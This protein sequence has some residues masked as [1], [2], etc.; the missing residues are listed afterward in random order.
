[1]IV[2]PMAE[3]TVHFYLDEITGNECYH[4]MKM[5]RSGRTLRDEE[6]IIMKM[7]LNI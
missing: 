3:A 4:L 5:K 7:A 1:M 2:S 6:E